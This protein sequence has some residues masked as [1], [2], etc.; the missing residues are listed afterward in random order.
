MNQRSK[1][2][3]KKAR[4]DAA[5]AQVAALP[6]LSDTLLQFAKPLLATLSDPPPIEEL[7]Q[8]M[9][10][11]TVVWNLPLYEQRKSPKA[12]SFRSMFDTMLK[13]V[14]TEI[15]KILSAMLSSRLTTY[16]LDPRLGFAEVVPD[17]R[18]GAQVVAKAMLTDD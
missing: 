7:S 14:P 10:V 9:V 1:R 6:K 16:A 13:Q 3:T 17:G 8:L 15:A 2:T 18:G 5:R 11:V 4:Q 12:I